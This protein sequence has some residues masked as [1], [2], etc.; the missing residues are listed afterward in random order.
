MA[1]RRDA[2]DR[3]AGQ[4]VRLA[5]GRA[6]DV[7]PADDRGEALEVDPVR[8]G[9]EADDRL[10]LAVLAGRDEDERLDDLADLGADDAGG[11]GGGVGGVG[12]GHDLEGHAL[13]GGG[14]Q[15]PLDGRVLEGGRHGGED[16]IGGRLGSARMDAIVFDWDGTLVDSLPAIFDANMRVLAEYGLPFDEAR[17]RAAYVPDWR[18]MYQRLGVPDDALDAAGRA[19][20]R[21]VPRDRRRRRSSRG[22]PSH[23]GGWPTPASCWASSPPA[24]ATS[25]R[26]SSSGSGS[27]TSC[28][29]RVFGNDDIA[30]QAASR[31][32]PARRSTSSAGRIGS[33]RARY[34]GDVPDDMRMARAVG[35]LGIGI[36]SSIGHA[37]RP[38]RARARR[39][40][41]PSVAEFVDDLLGTP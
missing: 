34:V 18:L 10:E 2:A 9:H 3:V 20:A 19:L 40:V 8:A 29:Y 22:S 17:Y 12:E 23:S 32:A 24:T 30:D 28:R 4:L 16:S 37:R 1:E 38:A 36:E 27:A 14:I 5:G 21:A 6:A 33:R 35:A 25:S 7:A 15:H 41:Y 31:P 39:A 13:S 26:P 11:V